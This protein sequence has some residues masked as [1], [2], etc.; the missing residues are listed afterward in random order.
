MADIK[1]LSPNSLAFIGLSN[2]YCHAIESASECEPDEFVNSMIRLLLAYIFR[3][4]ISGRQSDLT[5]WRIS[6]TLSTKPA[7][8]PRDEA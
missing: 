2:E 3:R 6:T 1:H 4:L 8:M 5:I 7:T